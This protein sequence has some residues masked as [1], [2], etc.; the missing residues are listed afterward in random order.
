MLPLLCRAQWS[1]MACV[2]NSILL[3]PGKDDVD[4][5]SKP[6]NKARPEL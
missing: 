1:V 3:R 5:D 4:A 2:L 6:V